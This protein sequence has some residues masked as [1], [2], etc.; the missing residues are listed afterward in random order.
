MLT[1]LLI[2]SLSTAKFGRRGLALRDAPAREII[3][4]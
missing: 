2:F 1:E 4:H 3:D